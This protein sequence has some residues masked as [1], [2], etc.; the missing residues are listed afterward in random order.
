MEVSRSMREVSVSHSGNEH[1]RNDMC[2]Q[3]SNHSAGLW[4]VVSRREC[5][6]SAE[7]S[8]FLGLR[9]QGEGT[10]PERTVLFQSKYI[11]D[12]IV[13]LS[14]HHKV[15]RKAGGSVLGGRTARE[16]GQSVVLLQDKP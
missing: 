12:G 10:E 9:L 8:R 11:H 5:G 13:Q 1:C 15:D 2:L 16:P 6:V 3:R 7:C 4:G 14:K